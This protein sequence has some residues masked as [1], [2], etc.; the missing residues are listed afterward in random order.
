[1]LVLAGAGCQAG[2]GSP[3]RRVA[4]SPP[5]VP[6]PTGGGTYSM[7]CGGDES[8]C[9]SGGVPAALRRPV[10]LPRIAAEA[11]CPVSTPG[12]KA[13]RNEVAAL[14]PGPV[15]A[16][17]LGPFAR[18]A[19]MPFVLP[20]PALFGG[21]AWGGQILKWIGTPSTMARCSSAAAS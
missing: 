12:R 15:Y 16:L 6:A 17:S 8:G 4:T 21:S 11:R 3:G 7:F 20:S 1:M 19:V 9:P 14:G 18:S 5:S 2:A 13:D 10:H